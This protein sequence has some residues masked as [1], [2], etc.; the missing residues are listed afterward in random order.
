M[1]PYQVYKPACFQDSYFL[2]KTPVLSMFFNFSFL[3]S[4]NKLPWRVLILSCVLNFVLNSMVIMEKENK[5]NSDVIQKCY[6]WKLLRSRL[7]SE[8]P[9]FFGGLFDWFLTINMTS[10]PCYVIRLQLI[11]PATKFQFWHPLKRS[12]KHLVKVMIWFLARKTSDC[13]P[14]CTIIVFQEEITVRLYGP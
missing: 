13:S 9:P 3:S 7:A 10:L 11:L 8:D 2:M 12:L 1:F 14:S 6:L 5:L 4:S